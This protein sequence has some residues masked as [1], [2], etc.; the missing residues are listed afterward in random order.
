M[1]V[2]IPYRIAARRPGDIACYY[3]NPS[4]A[5]KEPGWTASLDLEKMCEDAWRWQRNNPG[6]YACAEQAAL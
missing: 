5:A 6:G 3:A 2:L 1:A 4:R